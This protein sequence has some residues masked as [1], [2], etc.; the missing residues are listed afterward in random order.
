ML[1]LF[2]LVVDCTKKK[3]CHTPLKFS[4][5]LYPLISPWGLY[6][7]RLYDYKLHFSIFVYIECDLYHFRENLSGIF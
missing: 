7:S 5:H 1:F 6:D 3:K 2:H 4:E